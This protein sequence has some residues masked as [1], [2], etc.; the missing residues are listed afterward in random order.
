MNDKDI[1][2]DVIEELRN[3]RALRVWMENKT[4]QESFGITGLFTP[5]I[6]CEKNE[7]M[8][9]LKVKQ[10]NRAL[11]HSLDAIERKIIEQKYLSSIETNDIQI[12][13]DLG[14]KK[15]KFYEKKRSALLSLAKSLGK[16]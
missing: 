16:I 7:V 15:G 8:D 9:E 2:S 1:Q 4:E 14:L 6:K 12:Y 13:M 11:Q 10:I 3:Y 5:V